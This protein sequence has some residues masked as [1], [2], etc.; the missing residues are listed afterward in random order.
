MPPM[1]ASFRNLEEP[2]DRNSEANIEYHCFDQ[3]SYV[4]GTYGM[5]GYFEGR[6][7]GHTAYVNFFETTN[8]GE[9]LTPSTGSAVITYSDDWSAV[10]GP[11]W[12]S[13]ASTMPGSWGS[14]GATNGPCEKCIDHYQSLEQIRLQK[15][16]WNEKPHHNQLG[17]VDGHILGTE[18]SQNAFFN[19]GYGSNHTQ[20]QLVGG[21]AYTYTEKQCNDWGYNCYGTNGNREIGSYGHDSAQAA[22]KDGRIIA[23]K[24]QIKAGPLNGH[25]GSSL[26]KIFNLEDGKIG[27][28]GFFC[29]ADWLDVPNAGQTMTLVDCSLDIGQDLTV[30]Y[31]MHTDLLQ[32]AYGGWDE[33]QSD[34]WM[35]L[36]HFFMATNPN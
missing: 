14:W 10:D 1:L 34:A 29:A 12:N 18:Q 23:S 2:N 31:Q 16:L 33:H 7:D 11:F 22:V 30:D 21:Y 9:S 27:Y 3:N 5:R 4:R 8:D 6:L 32:Q 28:A 26:Y 25:I 24:L 15:C 19:I 20:G 36:N 13:G 35:R 17:D